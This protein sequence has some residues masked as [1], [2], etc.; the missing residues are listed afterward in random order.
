MD[1]TDKFIDDLLA[2]PSL[3][4]NS[5]NKQNSLPKH[6]Q[7]L[8]EEDSSISF[9]KPEL[10]RDKNADVAS[11]NS[12]SENQSK[13]LEEQIAIINESIEK[14]RHHLPEQRKPSILI[15]G[16]IGNGKTT[17]INTIF[18]KKVGEVG[19][20]SRGKDKDEVYEW[21]ACTEN[22][23]IVDLPGLG[24]SEKNDKIFQGIYRK[25]VKQA[26]GFIIVVSPP[27][28]TEYGTLKTV[29]LLIECGVSSK[30]IIF[31][32]NKL[33]N[34]RYEDNGR[35][36]EVQLDGLISPTTPNHSKAIADAKEAFLNDL[37]KEIPEEIFYE[38][39]IIEYDSLS[40]WNLHKML[41]A[42][43]EILPFEALAKL[44]QVATEA[45]IEVKKKEEEQLERELE[46]IHEKKQYLRQVEE[47]L[48]EIK[49]RKHSLDNL[50]ELQWRIKQA[51]AELLELQDKIQ[52]RDEVIKIF[53]DQERETD[54][55]FLDKALNVIGEVITRVNPVA[56][57]AFNG[58]RK[59]IEEVA[60]SA[61]KIVSQVGTAIAD[62][63]KKLVDGGKKVVQS[64][65]NFLGNIWNSITS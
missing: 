13:L 65:G 60:P 35:L 10:D 21:Q 36:Q 18:G 14:Y 49:A 37:R 27:R 58:A 9:I 7:S 20:Y 3:V 19:H 34:L 30:H 44:R 31:G 1:K 17:T 54:E 32:F 46:L 45:Q 26:D 22:I 29:K 25:H 64:V 4:N 33:S 55:K 40:G 16:K 6:Q 52:Q 43:I 42:V 56:G 11:H 48:D 15:C 5:L 8:S 24:D 51:Q 62:T 38:N 59:I 53:T 63:G 41:H 57:V 23:N 47:E 28:P 12:I 50:R 61:S 39:Q 2:K